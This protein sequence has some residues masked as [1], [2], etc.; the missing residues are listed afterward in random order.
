MLFWCLIANRSLE[1][2]LVKLVL[3]DLN[4]KK[5]GIYILVTSFPHSDKKVMRT[6]CLFYVS[7]FYP[8]YCVQ[9]EENAFTKNRWVEKIRCLFGIQEISDSI[10]TTQSVTGNFVWEQVLKSQKVQLKSVV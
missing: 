8:S 9:I 4:G 2:C 3:G 6:L 1:V 10:P 5:N 7:D